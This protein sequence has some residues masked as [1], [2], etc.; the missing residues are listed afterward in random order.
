VKAHQT[1]LKLNRQI[2]LPRLLVYLLSRINQIYPLSGQEVANKP[3][4]EK[5][6]LWKNPVRTLQLFSAVL[7]RFVGKIFRH[8]F[9]NIIYYII[10]AAIIIVPHVIHGPHTPVNQSITLFYTKSSLDDQEN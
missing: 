5:V 7:I 3:S 8:I 4:I 9:R 1:S 6:T 2:L 10:L